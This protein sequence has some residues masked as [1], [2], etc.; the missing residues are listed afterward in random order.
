MAIK[1]SVSRQGAQPSFE[2]F[3]HE[4]FDFKKAFGKPE[5]LKGYRVLSCTQYILGP[6]CASY[7]AELGAEVI[8]IEAPRR[9]EA[10]RH[11]TPFNEPFLYPLSKWIPERGTGLGF[12]G[13]NPNE[14]FISVDFHRP[15]G[16]AIVKK[17]AAKADVICENYRPGTFDRWGIGYRQ[18]KEIN[19]RLVYCWMGGF[20]GWGPG[21]V[22]AS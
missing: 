3:C 20:G 11:T 7:L 13:A 9:G 17:L 8:K 15:E 12:L 5:A 6:S 21:R 19:P 14:Y 2:E 4:T 22:R 16:Q 18:I 1:T 10:M